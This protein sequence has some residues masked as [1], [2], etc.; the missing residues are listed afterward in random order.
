[1]CRV[2]QGSIFLRPAP[3]KFSTRSDHSTVI[4]SKLNP[5]RTPGPVNIW[6][7]TRPRDK[8]HRAKIIQMNVL[9]FYLVLVFVF[10]AVCW[11]Y[12][13]SSMVVKFFSQRQLP[14][15]SLCVC[16][17]LT[18][19]D[20]HASQRYM[21]V[22]CHLNEH[23]NLKLEKCFIVKV[24]VLNFINIKR[25]KYSIKYVL[26]N[27]HLTS[28]YPPLL[29]YVLGLPFWQLLLQFRLDLLVCRLCILA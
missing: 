25:N 7:V 26:L 20:T 1:M 29:I 12:Q 8:S 19:W 13:S 24:S 3:A 21:R 18:H 16:V 14:N 28:C 4:I 10:R 23:L 11:R 6:P 2:L 9:Y 5:Q 27:A 22:L 17:H 15:R